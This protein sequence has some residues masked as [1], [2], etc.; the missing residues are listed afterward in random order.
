MTHATILLDDELEHHVRRLAAQQGRSA[1][2]L[3]REAVAEYVL[4]HRRKVQQPSFVAAGRSGRSDIAERH[5]EIIESEWGGAE[6][7]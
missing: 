4:R 7:S 5:E 2:N 3:L 1:E 6:A